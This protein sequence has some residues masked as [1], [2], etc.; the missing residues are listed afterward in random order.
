MIPAAGARSGR[1][2]GAHTHTHTHTMRIDLATLGWHDGIARQ[3]FIVPRTRSETTTASLY[4]RRRHLADAS[5][6]QTIHSPQ[7]RYGAH[8]FVREDE[9]DFPDLGRI[10]S[11]HPSIHPPTHPSNYQSLIR[12]PVCVV[13]PP[14]GHAH[15]CC[16]GSRACKVLYDD[17]DDD[18]LRGNQQPMLP[19]QVCLWLSSSLNDRVR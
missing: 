15:S 10:A 6:I 9:H 12:A 8:L 19:S 18:A 16:F 1:D 4:H 11:I 7:S 5:S 17:D 2:H 13:C 3:Y 14:N